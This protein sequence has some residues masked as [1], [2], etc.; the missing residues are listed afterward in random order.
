MKDPYD[1]YIT[2]E[3]YDHAFK[4]GIAKKTLDFRI[5]S[6][7]WDKE[8]AIN[9]PIEIYDSGWREWKCI[10]ERNGICYGTYYQRRKYGGM[11]PFE[12]ATNPVLTKEQI[13]QKA[14]ESKERVFTDEEIK[15]AAENGITYPRLYGRYKS[16]WDKE[17]AISEPLV[18]IEEAIKRAR[19]KSSLK[20]TFFYWGTSRSRARSREVIVC[21]GSVG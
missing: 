20:S 18:P 4:N 13:L 8:T 21:K 1:F 14:N 6:L 7:G 2:D 16:G 11:S 17:R 12:A 10:A 3:E 9:K 19:E 5:R 15:R